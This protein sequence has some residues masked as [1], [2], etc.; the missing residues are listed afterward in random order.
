MN[1]PL[2]NFGIP[3]FLGRSETSFR[4]VLPRRKCGQY[5]WHG[6]GLSIIKQSVEIHRGSIVFQ[7]NEENGTIFT[8]AIST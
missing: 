2:L 6:L 4:N 7:S 8:V 3:I 5:F 1:P